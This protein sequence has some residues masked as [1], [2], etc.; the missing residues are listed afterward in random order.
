MT[1]TRKTAAA[2]AGRWRIAEM[3]L[4]DQDAIDLLGPA[5]IAFDDEAMGEFRFCAVE[6]W[7]DCRFGQRDGLPLVEFS[8]E[9]GDDADQACG[10]GWT[11][12]EKDGQLRG[13][14]FFH[15]GDDWAFTAGREVGQ[16]P[17]RGRRRS[18]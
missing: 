2:F 11:V 15:R 14:L 17:R 9:G 4:W 13:R 10:R 16:A 7:I 12:I 18:R 3:E 6:G 8:W 5:F 1:D